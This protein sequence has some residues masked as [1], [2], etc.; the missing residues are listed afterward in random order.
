M[1]MP[2]PMSRDN[3]G[4]YFYKVLGL[5]NDCSSEQLKSA[6]KKLVLKW[7]PDRISASKII[8]DAKKRYLYDLGM[9]NDADEEDD[10]GMC[11]FLSEIAI[12][13]EK[14]KPAENK[15]NSFQDLQNL[16]V[17][18]FL[19]PVPTMSP[20]TSSSYHTFFM[21]QDAPTEFSFVGNNGS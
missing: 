19:P 17:G 15:T 16:F 20:T 13:M 18:M 12:L 5:D 2:M 10:N 6:Y 9:Y 7:H 8:S 4:E 3:D 21:S 11:D 1:S 14:S